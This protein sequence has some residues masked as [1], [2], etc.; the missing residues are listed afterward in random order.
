MQRAFAFRL[1]MLQMLQLFLSFIEL[2]VHQ[3]RATV[4]ILSGKM[5]IAVNFYSAEVV[6]AGTFIQPVIMN[7]IDI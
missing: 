3:P 4:S 6:V 7:H 2:L 5:V 1:L